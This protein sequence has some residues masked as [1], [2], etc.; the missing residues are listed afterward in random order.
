MGGIHRV[1]AVVLPGVRVVVVAG[2]R[3]VV[4][5]EVRVAVTGIPV[6]IILGVLFSSLV[7]SKERWE[8]TGHDICR[9][10]FS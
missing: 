8:K 6:V 3:V 1:R 5:P 4:L 9:G 7:G 2:I 10:P